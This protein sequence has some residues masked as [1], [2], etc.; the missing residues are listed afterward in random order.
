MGLNV[1]DSSRQVKH[2]DRKQLYTD[3]EARISY[4]HGFLDFNSSMSC[5]TGPFS[6]KLMRKI[7][8]EKL[9]R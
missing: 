1:R 2:V 8:N 6:I 3:L 4:L 7:A 9:D 5:I